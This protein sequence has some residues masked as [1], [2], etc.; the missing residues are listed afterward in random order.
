MYTWYA[1]IVASFMESN[2]LGK[3]VENRGFRHQVAAAVITREPWS[4]HV[5]G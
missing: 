4:R 2:G 3:H 5:Q 1:L